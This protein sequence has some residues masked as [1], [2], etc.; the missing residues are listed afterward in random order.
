[1]LTYT[2]DLNSQTP[3]YLQLYNLIKKDVL[4]QVLKPDEH[5]PSKRS[6]AKNLGISTITIENAYAQLMAEGYIYSL[7]KKGYFVAD[8]TDRRGF[9]GSYESIPSLPLTTHDTANSHKAKGCSS[10][11]SNGLPEYT[12]NALGSNTEQFSEDANYHL[13]ADFTSNRTNPDNFP[14]SIW[15]K[16]LREELS[17][18]KYA[19]MAKSPS[20]GIYKLRRS[21]AAHLKAFRGM[22]VAPEQIIIGAGTDYLYGLIIQLLGRDKIYCVENP[23]YKNITQIYS[24]NNVNYCHAD[25]DKSGLS[26][27]AL[28]DTNA[29]IV[30]ISP[31]H[32]FPTGITMPISRR[33]ELLN[34]AAEDK[35]R[36]IIED[37]YDSEFRLTGNPIPSLQSIDEGEKV[38][39]IN[40]FSKSL[41]STIRISYMVLPPHLMERF[42]SELSFYSCTVSNFEQYTLAE[43][44]DRGY[45]EKHINRMRLYYGRQREALLNAIKKS[46]L[47]DYITIIEEDSGLHFLIKIKTQLPDEVLIERF[48]AEKIRITELSRYY[49]T[50]AP[51]AAHTFIINYSNIDTGKLS[52]II[53]VMVRILLNLPAL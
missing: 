37:D 17:E 14:F 2:F 32:H 3:L 24:H 35:E 30:H 33:Y 5:L 21:I 38:I 41:A 4:T 16:I 40:T 51:E 7:P 39:Y 45:F 12:D 53:Q 13:L 19:L 36:Y 43:F 50:P 47:A 27:S 8:L 10:V 44:I 1:M 18:N 34:W 9:F 29:H 23:G 42:N 20:C 49:N 31:T 26:V 52:E 25:M 28:R 11:N 6:F 46:P 48:L 15:S 22:M